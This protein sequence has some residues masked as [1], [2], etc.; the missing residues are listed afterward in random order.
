[1]DL[2]RSF[3]FRRLNPRGPWPRLLILTSPKPLPQRGAYRYMSDGHV[4]VVGPVA[5]AAEG[6][7]L[8]RTAIEAENERDAEPV[9]QS[10]V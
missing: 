8:I 9:E 3:L 5:R 10:G 7:A 1:M 2:C 6:R 4:V